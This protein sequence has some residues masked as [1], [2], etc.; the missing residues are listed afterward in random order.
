MNTKLRY[1]FL[2]ALIIMIGISKAQE[3][4]LDFPVL[5]GP[6]LGQSPP[7]LNPEI[8]LPGLVSTEL[9]EH[10]APAFSPDL[11]EI[12][13]SPQYK[14]IGGGKII[15]MK[16][17][18]SQWLAPETAPFSEEFKNQNPFL[19]LDGERLFF[20][21]F[22]PTEA[23]VYKNGAFWV[24][25][26]TPEGWSVPRPLDSSVNSGSMGQQ[27]TESRDRNL[28]YASGHPGGKGYW[29]IYKVSYDTG[30]YGKPE[31]LG[32]A[33]NTEFYD[34]SPYIAPDEDHIIFSSISCPDGYGG[35]DLYISFKNR[36]GSWL[37]ATNLGPV[38]NTVKHES[39][40]LVS[41][42]GNYLFFNSNRPSS[43]NQK[44]IEDGPGNIYWVK[45][46]FIEELKEASSDA[47]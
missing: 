11:S 12:Y 8:F 31:N 6:Y 35:S 13:W 36:D 3:K 45:T 7:G 41:P 18:D 30:F 4:V 14:E 20:K 47:H 23:D 9:N 44:P 37:K 42:D 33:I 1:V 26:R 16:A 34:G 27:I 5:K 46:T 24:C 21:S 2:A 25:Q 39:F 29:D 32:D 10:G 17:V 28:Y 40:P 43:L 19:S 15:F 22:R 38:I